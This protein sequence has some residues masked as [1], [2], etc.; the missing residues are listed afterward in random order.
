MEKRKADCSCTRL[1]QLISVCLM[2]FAA[3][4]LGMAQTIP[5]APV[6]IS[7]DDSTRAY[8]VDANRW[9]GRINKPIEATKPG[10][11]VVMF[12]TNVKDLLPG[13]GAN[14]FRSYAEDG[15]KREYI[16]RIESFEPVKGMDWVY[17]VRVALDPNIES[18]GDV[19]VRIT[20][21]GMTTNRVRLGVGYAGDGPPNDEGSVPTPMP[22]KQPVESKGGQT[23]A[24]TPVNYPDLI[25]FMQQ[26][27]Y[28]PSPALEQR[29]RRIGIHVWLNEQFNMPLPTTDTTPSCDTTTG[30]CTI[31]PDVYPNL[32]LQ[33]INQPTTCTGDCRRNSYSQY[34]M[35]RW[36]YTNA[37]YGQDQLRRRVAW[38]LLQIAVVA[39]PDV[40]QPS[41]MIEYQKIL[42][43]N[44][45][46]NYR[47]LLREVTLSPAMGNYLDMFLSTRFSPNENYAREINQLFA[48]GL[49]EL[50]LDGTYKL[51]GN[52]QL[53]PT[54]TQATIDNFTKVMTGWQTCNGGA[55]CPNAPPAG[56]GIPNYIDPLLLNQNLHDTTA[57]TL[58]NYPGAPFP[59]I[60]A[61]QNGNV[62]LEQALDN[63]YNH[64]NVAPFVTKNL[65][66]HLVTSDPSPAYIQRVATVF[67]T[68]RTDANQMRYVIYAILTDPE[69]RGNVKNDPRYGML[70]EPVL[71]TTN[72]LRQFGAKAFT[73]TG[74]DLTAA[75][76]AGGIP[77]CSDGAVNDF[78][79]IM[80]QN[81]YMSPSVFN[82]Y[83]PDYIVPNTN[84]S[85]LGPEFAIYTTS[86][87][88]QRANFVNQFAMQ[89]GYAN[90]TSAN[91]NRPFGTSID[92]T[93]LQA[94][95]SADTTG[96]Q[97]MN[98]LNSKLMHGTMS[99]SMR[100]TILTAVTAV[101]ATSDANHLLRARTAL[102]LVLTSSQ[103]QV[104]K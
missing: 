75:P 67:N 44:A 45:F 30:I 74:C 3:S 32:P 72:A 84:P 100:S 57:K 49:F 4:V 82:F 104:Q 11:S 43:R 41:W 48:V 66:Q 50:N 101:P 12:L 19:L 13:E 17:A 37:L 1:I 59:T 18:V 85:V 23:E 46:G 9:R 31:L 28:G 65:I 98:L 16:F 2:I 15:S 8:A 52:N 29:L 80:G 51:D 71:L 56:S 7:K 42:D 77:G 90:T 22:W 68:Y 38:S 25:R 95:S 91:T 21:R 36:F 20:W 58:Y 79:Q 63:I 103:Y 99:A 73:S 10:R 81:V 40:Q 14:A 34:P 60:A 6:L 35:Q 53:I 92:L 47:T 89:T 93:G 76:V 97:L 83:P 96:N 5:D 86:T 62:E 64:P 70:R 27:T 78:S 61:G 39:G 88:F 33:P 69:A 24:V 55:S 26:A 54:Y 94:A 102:Y 87:A